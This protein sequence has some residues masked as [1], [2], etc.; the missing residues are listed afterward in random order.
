MTNNDEMACGESLLAG[1]LVSVRRFPS[2][3]A[4]DVAGRTLDYATL[5]GM[6]ARV[7][8]TLQHYHP[9]SGVK[10]TAVLAHRSDTA[11]AGILGAL[12]LGHGYVPLNPKFPADR[13]ITMIERSGSETLIVGLEALRELEE[14]LQKI[15]RRLVVL[16]PD[17]QDVETLRDQFPDH[18]FIGQA[19]LDAD[20]DWRPVTVNANEIAYLLFTSGS[21]GIP[22]GVPVT[23][24]N[25]STFVDFCVRHYEF[26]EHDRFSQMFELVFDLSLFDMFVAWASGACVCCPSEGDARLPARFL[27]ESAITVWFSVPSLALNMKGAGLHTLPMDRR[28]GTMGFIARPRTDWSAVPRINCVCGR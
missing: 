14:I 27:K 12:M 21:T 16:I 26:D 10:L 4:L 9:D 3:P 20:S 17:C 25:I 19:D 22:K 2:R 15:S 6:A 11:F 7:A 18:A 23:H 28:Q 1:F 5:H 13:T 8:A 24:D